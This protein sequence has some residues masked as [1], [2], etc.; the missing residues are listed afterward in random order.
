MLIVFLSVAS[1]GEPSRCVAAWAGAV[2]GCNIRQTFEVAG[3]GANEAAATKSAREALKDALHKYT[4]AWRL[5]AP[6]ADPKEVAACDA[7]ADAAHAECFPV[8]TKNEKAYC[9][10]T[11]ADTACWD[12]EV[13]N[14]ETQDWK[15]PDA[16]RKLMCAAVDK[17]VVEQNYSGVDQRR[18]DCAA[19]CAGNTKVNCP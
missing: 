13:L 6:L 11:F 16:G 7:K 4:M 2:E 8:P 1:A 15:A 9:F 5:S 18:A 12:G 19:S 10:I 3:G 14:V 17:R